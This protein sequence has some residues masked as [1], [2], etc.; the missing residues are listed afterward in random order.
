MLT[1]YCRWKSCYQEEEGWDLINRFNPATFVV[2]VQ[3]QDL[4]FKRDISW[5]FFM[6][7]DLMQEVVVRFLLLLVKLMTITV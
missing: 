7:S 3:S 2:P 4:D 1:T 6:L 5:Y